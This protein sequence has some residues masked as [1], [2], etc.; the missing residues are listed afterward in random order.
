MIIAD[1]DHARLYLCVVVMVIILNTQTTIIKSFIDGTDKDV[2][3][4][5][6]HKIVFISIL[7]QL[8]KFNVNDRTEFDEV[9]A[10]I[11][12]LTEIFSDLETASIDMLSNK[13]KILTKLNKSLVF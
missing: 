3:N 4:G 11:M 13:I 1:M 9:I 10:L 8:L 6:V 7:K 12:A 5:H 2:Y